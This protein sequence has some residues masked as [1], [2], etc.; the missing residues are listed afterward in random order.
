MR[1]R[2][3]PAWGLLLVIA[4]A[5]GVAGGLASPFGSADGQG[6]TN[7]AER[8]A[9]QILTV[10][11][12]NVATTGGYRII[13]L[14]WTT[15]NDSTITH[16][17]YRRKQGTGAYTGWTPMA[18]TNAQSVNHLLRN[19]PTGV[20]LAFQVRA[21]NG[22]GRGAPSAEKT[23]TLRAMAATFTATALEKTIRFAWSTDSG[24]SLTGVG[25]WDIRSRRLKNVANPSA[26]VRGL[27]QRPRQAGGAGQLQRPGRR[28]RPGP[29]LP[30]GARGAAPVSHPRGLL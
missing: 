13:R 1:R 29:A 6:V 9:A 8:P 22:A 5:A 28:A 21:V 25:A 12:L 15:P 24:D 17:E 4:L 18:G 16:W 20:A 23:I 11:H 30:G 2:R 3:F 26:G 27:G 14:A 7:P 19:Q 10:S